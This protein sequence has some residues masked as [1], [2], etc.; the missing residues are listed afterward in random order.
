MVLRCFAPYAVSSVGRSS[1]D[2]PDKKTNNFC[3][4]VKRTRYMHMLGNLMAPIS[5]VAS[6]EAKRVSQI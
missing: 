1:T 3:S 4:H 2:Q 6:A 5:A